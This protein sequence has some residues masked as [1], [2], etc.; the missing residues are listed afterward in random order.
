MTCAACSE[1]QPRGGRSHGRPL[2]LRARRGQG[3]GRRRLGG[4]MEAPLL[5][6]GVQGQ[7][8]QPR[9][10]VRPTEA[11]RVGAGE[12]AAFDR[13]GHAP[14]PDPDELDELRQQDVRVWAGRSRG[15]GRSGQAPVGDVGSGA[16]AA[17]RDPGRR[18]RNGP[19]K[20]SRSLPSRSATVAMR[21]RRWPTSSTGSCSAC[22]PRT[23]DCFPTTCSRAC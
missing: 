19:P 18:S 22:S 7:A 9:H 6:V 10:R 14:V 2:L 4:R 23:W 20:R 17:R 12:P 13:L 5:R 15:R 1:S 21:Q 11:I 16:S 8:R 3:L